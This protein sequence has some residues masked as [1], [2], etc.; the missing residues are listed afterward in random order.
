MRRY[1]ALLLLMIANT[2]MAQLSDI[3]EPIK[4][5]TGLI[6]LR[7]FDIYATYF[8]EKQEFEDYRNRPSICGNSYSAMKQYMEYEEEE[9]RIATGSIDDGIFIYLKRVMEYG[10]HKKK[11]RP[12][13]VVRLKSK[14]LQK[15]TK[16][17]IRA[18]VN[19]AINHIWPCPWDADMVTINIFGAVC[20]VGL[21]EDRTKP[22]KASI[23]QSYF[24]KTMMAD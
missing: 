16:E 5:N 10:L 7:R 11:Y 18:E 22:T 23:K 12:D 21:N 24:Y 19:R 3:M 15:Y 6:R 2:C 4:I 20:D 9:F 13:Y 14:L 1:I 17:Q 8:L